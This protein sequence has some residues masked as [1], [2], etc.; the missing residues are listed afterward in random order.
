MLWEQGEQADSKRGK[1]GVRGASWGLPQALGRFQGPR[2]ALGARE[3]A[4]S[5]G[6]KLGVRGVS[7]KLPEA[8]GRFQGPK[9]ALG[10]RGATW[11]FLRPRKVPEIQGYSERKGSK[12]GARGTS[13]GLPEAQGRF[14]R[15]RDALG[16]REQAGSEGSK[17]SKLGAS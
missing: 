14:Q 17:G 11:G 8:L 16:A 13:W 12:L 1:L 9:A 6:S 7:W 10:A 3:Q 15:P 4:D 5:K 2:D